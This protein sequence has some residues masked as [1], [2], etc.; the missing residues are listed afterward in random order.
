MTLSWSSTPPTPISIPQAC[1][2]SLDTV[3]VKG[4][5]RC[6]LS[7]YISKVQRL[8]TQTAALFKW[9]KNLLP[10]LLSLDRMLIVLW[11]WGDWH[12]TIEEFRSQCCWMGFLLVLLL[13]WSSCQ[14]LWFRSDTSNL[15][16]GFFSE[17]DAVEALPNKHF[18]S[19]CTA[20]GS[21]GPSLCFTLK[22]GECGGCKE[23]FF[24]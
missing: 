18:L 10:H 11:L 17:S 13:L 22:P 14:C 4:C 16:D 21:M 19:H 9:K 12:V 15:P 3:R 2:H 5:F 20:E 8:I 24:F 1:R 23:V 6:K 7:R